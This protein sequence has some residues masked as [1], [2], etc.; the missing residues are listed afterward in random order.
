M[1]LSYHRGG[2]QTG[3]SRSPSCVTQLTTVPELQRT[4]SDTSYDE[5]NTNPQLQ[6]VDNITVN[7]SYGGALTLM[8]NPAYKS[9]D[10][11][12]SKQ[13]DCITYEE[14]GS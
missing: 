12:T 13:T 8:N 3:I 1:S 9:A 4:R 2:K 14:T 6:D 7:P 10:D 5:I 11:F